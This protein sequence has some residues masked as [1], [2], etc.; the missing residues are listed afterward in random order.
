MVTG[1]PQNS[2]VVSGMQCCTD[3]YLRR[4]I[5]VILAPMPRHFSRCGA[6]RAAARLRWQLG[7]IQSYCFLVDKTWPNTSRPLTFTISD[8]S[9]TISA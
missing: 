2:N 7:Q 8:I 1:I 6:N 4:A 5:R 9:Q 3:A